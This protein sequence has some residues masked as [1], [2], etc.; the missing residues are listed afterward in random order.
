M[1]QGS[2]FASDFE[3][4]ASVLN[5]AEFWIY[6]GPECAELLNMLLFWI[7]HSLKY[8]RVTPSSKYAWIISGH[9]WLCLNLP[10]FVWIAFVLHSPIV[11][12]YLK[13]SYNVFLES[14]NLIFSI[15][16]GSIWF[17]FFFFLDWMFL[18]VRFQICYYLWGPKGLGD[19]NL[20]QP[21][22]WYPVNISMTLF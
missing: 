10:K 3:Y 19:L 9:V 14:K 20:T 4:A 11:I 21:V 7:Y 13:E 5:V 18:Q 8:V 12:S 17:F 2:E 16:A 22:R 1:W 6:Q 15:V